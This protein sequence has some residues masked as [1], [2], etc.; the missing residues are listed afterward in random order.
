MTT[1]GL[2]VFPSIMRDAQAITA[3]KN[4]YFERSRFD[5]FKLGGGTSVGRTHDKRIT[6]PQM[7]NLKMLI[8]VE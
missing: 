2:E 1:S 3:K 4:C 7:C 5:Y 8:R 6:S